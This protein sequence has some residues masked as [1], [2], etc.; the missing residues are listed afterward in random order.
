VVQYQYKPEYLERFPTGERKKLAKPQTGVIA[1]VISAL[2]VTEPPRIFIFS[3]RKPRP[4]LKSFIFHM[5]IFQLGRSTD[6]V[7]YDR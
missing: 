2:K 7:L 4:A 3:H 5:I 1:Q 6:F